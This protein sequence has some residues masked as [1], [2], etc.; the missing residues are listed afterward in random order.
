VKNVSGKKH[1]GRD[2]NENPQGFTVRFW[3]FFS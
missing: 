3:G 1:L 2:Q